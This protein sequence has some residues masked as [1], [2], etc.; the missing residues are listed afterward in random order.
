[1][2][3]KLSI[4]LLPVRIRRWR[5]LHKAFVI[6][7]RCES[8]RGEDLQADKIAC[9]QY[10]IFPRPLLSACLQHGGVLSGSLA[11]SWKICLTAKI[12]YLR[13]GYWYDTICLSQAIWV[14]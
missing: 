2:A 8:S 4:D 12:T 3:L 7:K 1:M 11:V 6:P 13:G 5:I 9:V 10:S 14:L